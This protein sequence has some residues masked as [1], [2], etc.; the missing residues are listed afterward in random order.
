MDI[1]YFFLEINFS[2]VKTVPSLIDLKSLMKIIV[3][4]KQN[5][6]LMHLCFKVALRWLQ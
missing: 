5:V 4:V 2:T 6:Q 3:L 1:L